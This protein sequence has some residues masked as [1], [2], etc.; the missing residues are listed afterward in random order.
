MRVEWSYQSPS[1]PSPVALVRR[2]TRNS[3]SGRPRTK[4]LCLH[5]ITKHQ[6]AQ[7]GMPFANGGWFNTTGQQGL[8]CGVCLAAF[9]HRYSTAAP[10]GTLEYSSSST[11]LKLQ[12]RAHGW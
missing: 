7:R 6:N 12:A 8:S 10:L 2:T 9:T 4:Y 11:F 5:T 1:S 3:R